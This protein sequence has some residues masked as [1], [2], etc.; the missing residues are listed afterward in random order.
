[1]LGRLRAFAF[2][3]NHGFLPS[4][5]NLHTA[6]PEDPVNPALWARL[7]FHFRLLL[8]SS[9]EDDERGEGRV[10]H[11]ST[12]HKLPVRGRSGSPHCRCEVSHTASGKTIHDRRVGTAPS[13]V[14][15]P[16]QDH[17]LSLYPRTQGPS[18]LSSPALFRNDHLSL[19][20]MEFKPQRPVA[21]V[22]VGA[23][24]GTGNPQAPQSSA[25]AG[26]CRSRVRPV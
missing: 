22:D 17:T 23:E 2:F 20:T 16:P 11:I 7:N 26:R 19:V 18:A 10:Q 15:W 14:P 24:A 5:K 13:P 3:P 6:E 9:G 1:M 12:L 25:R 8:V 4:G 21:Q